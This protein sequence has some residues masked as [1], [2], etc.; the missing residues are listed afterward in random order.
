[1]VLR[2]VGSHKAVDQHV[3]PGT[4]LPQQV[5]LKSTYKF[6]IHDLKWAYKYWQ[7]FGDKEFDM[8]VDDG[9]PEST[10][11]IEKGRCIRGKQFEI[12]RIM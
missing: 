11:E 8:E 9:N 3:P 10:Q 7:P 6:N 1:M 5:D 2:T 12:G 4:Y